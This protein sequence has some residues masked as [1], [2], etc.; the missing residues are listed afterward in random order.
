[1]I[2]KAKKIEHSGCINVIHIPPNIEII[3][4]GRDLLCIDTYIQ[5]RRTIKKT[6]ANSWGTYSLK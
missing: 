3:E 6:S 2:N 4:N 5:K 1:M